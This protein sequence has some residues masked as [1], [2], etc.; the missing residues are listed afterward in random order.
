MK[1][2]APLFDP[3]PH[4]QTSEVEQPQLLDKDIPNDVAEKR[5]LPAYYCAAYTNATAGPIYATQFYENKLTHF[6]MWFDHFR[7]K[8]IQSKKNKTD[9]CCL[10]CFL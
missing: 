4:K 1:L 9:S 10:L 5:R 2:Q 3:Y 7:D 6:V 8:D